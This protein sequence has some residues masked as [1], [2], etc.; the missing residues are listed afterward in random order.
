MK[1]I[2]INNITREQEYDEYGLGEPF[3]YKTNF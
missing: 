2:I 3:K 1:D